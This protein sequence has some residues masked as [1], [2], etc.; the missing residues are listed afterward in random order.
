MKRLS[1]QIGITYFSVLAVAFYLQEAIIAAL[2]A[3]SFIAAAALIA[4]KRTRRTIYLPVVALTIAIACAVHLGWTYLRVIPEQDRYAGDSRRIEATL[5]DEMY[6]SYSKYCYRLRADRIDEF[7]TDV[8]LLLKTS[9]PLDAEPF[10]TI[11]FTSDIY[12][13][14]NR[15]DLAKG[16]YLSV[17]S[18]T[19]AF[20]VRT[21]EERPLYY[22][23]IQLRRSLCDALDELLPP[24]AAGLC[25]AVFIGDKYAVSDDTKNSFRYAGASYFI[26]VSGMHFSIICLLLFRFLRRRHVNRFITFGVTLFIVLL[27]IFLTG[28]QP[29]VI[30]A[31]IMMI[32]YLIACLIRRVG[33]PHSS[34]GVA[35]IVSTFVFT[36]YGAGDIGLIL[37]FAATFAIITWSDP[38]CCRMSF[39]EPDH[40]IKRAVNAVMR[41]ISVTLAANILVFP[42]SVFVFKAF[43]AVTLASAL[44]LYLPIE[45][46]LILSSAVC[47]LFYLG[48]LRYLSILLSWP[49]YA[50]AKAVLW[51]VNG[52]ASLPFSYV[53]IHHDFF[54]WW[55]GV[56]VIL[57]VTVYLFRRRYRLFSIAAL[58]SLLLLIGGTVINT[59]IQLHTVELRVFACGE[60]LTVGL[61]YHGDL[62]LFSF[63]S[64]TSYAYDIV[65]DLSRR[66]DTARFAV[67]GEELDYRNYARLTDN[68]FAIERYMV[69]DKDMFADAGA[70]LTAYDEADVYLLEDDVTLRVSCCKEMLLSYLTVGDTD[71]L[72]IPPDYPS[73][74]I[75][76]EYRDAEIVITSRMTDADQFTSCGTMILSNTEEKR[77]ALTDFAISDRCRI[78]Y[79]GD[80]DITVPLE[81]Y[82]VK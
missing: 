71:V 2:L 24:D 20:D 18:Y 25:K 42:I 64:K 51:A 29:S 58:L 1:A 74:S 65:G 66:Y 37:S 3:V 72:I 41:P 23:V 50:L 55:M 6:R 28:F 7:D 19:R 17:S 77:S 36:P 59:V 15:T 40:W 33:D 31:G 82:H 48:P 81:G 73:A 46:I 13:T 80:N 54:Y 49:L 69:Y 79:T 30:R 62:Y 43:S 56:T 52:I 53:R 39:K 68:E 78:L 60:G 75:P 38:I 32:M 67:C 34:L 16:Y 27:Y 35:G 26:V 22:R 45:L 57:G 47:L 70:E 21:A 9:K 4:V 10:D 14:D 11:T 12:R 5:T 63:H 76:K 44:V 8:K 61:D